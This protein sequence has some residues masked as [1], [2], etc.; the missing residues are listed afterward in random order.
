MKK[1]IEMLERGEMPSFFEVMRAIDEGTAC[2]WDFS[3]APTR[4][5]CEPYPKTICEL[6]GRVCCG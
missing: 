2:G 1:L 5:D 3:D 4:P 6:N